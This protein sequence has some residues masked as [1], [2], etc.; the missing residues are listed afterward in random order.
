MTQTLEL[1]DSILSLKVWVI[2]CSDCTHGGRFVARI[3]L[4]RIFKIGVRASRTVDTDVSSHGDV[5]ASVG[6]AHDSYNGDSTCS[7]N[8]LSL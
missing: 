5:R 3:T 1:F 6:L 8:R 2:A 4:S 7:A